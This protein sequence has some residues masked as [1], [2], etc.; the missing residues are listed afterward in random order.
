MKHLNRK[1]ERGAAEKHAPR[2]GLHTA[3]RKEFE[4]QGC[5]EVPTRT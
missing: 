2:D 4:F 5:V 1:A 3:H